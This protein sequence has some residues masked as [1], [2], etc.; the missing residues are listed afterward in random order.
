VGCHTLYGS[1]NSWLFNRAHVNL[2]CFDCHVFS[3]DAGA[4]AIP[5]FHNQAQKYQVC[6]MCYVAIHGSNSSR[7]FF[8]P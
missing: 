5:T 3:V 6:T 1:S 4:P 7:V 2:L 8:I